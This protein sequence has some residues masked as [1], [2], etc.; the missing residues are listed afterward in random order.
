MKA[1]GRRPSRKN[2]FFCNMCDDRLPAGGIEMD[3]AVLFA[4]VRGSTALGEKLGPTAF[5]ELLNRFYATATQVLLPHFAIIDKMIG[6]EV[7]ALFIPFGDIPYRKTAA[8]AAEELLRAVGYGDPGEPWLPLGAAVHSGLAYVGKVGTAGVNDFTAL[9]D[10]VNTA[11]RLQAEAKAGE[12]ILSDPV[13]ADVA[14]RYPLAIQ[15]TV[16]LRGKKEPLSIRVLRLE[17][18][19]PN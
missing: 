18:P 6:D 17:S 16:N 9:G 11:S 10:T 14:D 4:D 13:F 15:R 7:M 12:M 8:I 3:I 2:P 19:A 5:A 1:T